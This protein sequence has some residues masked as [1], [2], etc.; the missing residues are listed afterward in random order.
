[1]LF[2]LAAVL[3]QD[4]VTVAVPAHDKERRYVLLEAKLAGA[5]PFR[6]RDKDSGAVLAAQGDG[7]VVRWLVTSIPAASKRTF[8][9]EK[10]EAAGTAPL[11]LSE[12]DGVISI[13]ASDR[14]ITRW[15]PAAGIA[16]KKPCF[17]PLAAHG[18]NV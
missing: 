8:I 16:N 6:A 5:G 3:A 4:P 9:V 10:G 1:M 18:V 11:T 17:Y 12:S 15:H 2:L 13:K 14:E 7:A